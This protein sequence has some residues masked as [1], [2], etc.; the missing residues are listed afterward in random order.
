M[1]FTRP[2]APAALEALCASVDFEEARKI[3]LALSELVARL[4]EARL[5]GDDDLREVA[6]YPDVYL[7][8]SREIVAT[9]VQALGLAGCVSDDDIAYLAW[10]LTSG[11]PQQ[12]GREPVGSE[13]EAS[14]FRQLRLSCHWWCQRE[15]LKGRKRSCRQKT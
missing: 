10:L 4:L 2:L 1:A 3:R 11:V 15:S 7:A 8:R 6:R 9:R 13:L 12:A 14:A 5:L